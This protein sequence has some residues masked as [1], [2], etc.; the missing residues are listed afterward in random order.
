MNYES[1]KPMSAG[2][3]DPPRASMLN[4]FAEQL[5]GQLSRMY[6]S[7]NTL[8]VTVDRLVLQ[9]DGQA[10]GTQPEAHDLST[11]LSNLLNYFAYQNERFEQLN[12]KLSDLI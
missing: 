2:L 11:R 8:S 1:P 9:K 10:T 6:N 4:Q 5:D 12:N 7:L 3:A